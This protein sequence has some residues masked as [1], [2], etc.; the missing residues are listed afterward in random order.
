MTHNPNIIHTPVTIVG[1]GLTGL[2]QAIALAQAGLAVTVIDKDNFEIQNLPEA[3]GRVSAISLGS[4]RLLENIGAWAEMKNF[5]EPILDI[6]VQDKN[7]PISVHYDHR[8]VGTEPM[9]HILENRH[10]RM[11]LQRRAATLPL[12][13]M[14]APAMWQK[15]EHSPSHAII[16]LSDNSQIHTQLIIAAD[17]KFSKL[18][19]KAGISVTQSDYAQTAIVA[20]IHHEKPHHGLA[21]ENFLPAG[22]FAVL[23]MQG[24]RSSL[25]WVEPT[26]RAKAMLSLSR[27]EKEIQITHRIGDYLGKITLEGKVFSYPLMLTFAKQFAD[28]RIAL[29][30]DAAHGIHPVAGQG[31]NLGYRDVAALTEIVIGAA[32]IGQDFGSNLVLE[33]YNQSRRVDAVTMIAVTDGIVK[34]FSNNNPILKFARNLGLAAVE[35]TAPAKSFFM[36]HAMGIWAK[37]APLMQQNAA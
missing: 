8:D 29:I 11:A 5:A 31:V 15:V 18:R 19:E 32:K 24:N 3:D 23:P 2:A 7:S 36:L 35:K 14:I 1:A 28:N 30:G 26:A 21:R 27:E 10:I 6:V 9:G 25:V 20:T 13:T 16:H 4:Q 12:I 22:P 17:G 33:G 37:S 34:L